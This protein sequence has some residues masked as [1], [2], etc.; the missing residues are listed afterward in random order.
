MD[1]IPSQGIYRSRL[2][3]VTTNRLIVNHPHSWLAAGKSRSANLA[4]ALLW[5]EVWVESE[6]SAVGAY[7]RTKTRARLPAVS[8]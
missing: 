3:P 5:V 6:A 2:F 7:S 4:V 1:P 8:F